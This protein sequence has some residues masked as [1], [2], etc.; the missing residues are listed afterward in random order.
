[1]KC[2]FGLLYV[3]WEKTDKPVDACFLVWINLRH[4]REITLTVVGC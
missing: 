3:N 2:K 1:M 4:K